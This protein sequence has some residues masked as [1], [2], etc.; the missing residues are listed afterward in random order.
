MYDDWFLCLNLKHNK[1]TK[2]VVSLVSLLINQIVHCSWR[3]LVV[4]ALST[5]EPKRVRPM[6]M[7]M[8]YAFTVTQQLVLSESITILR[9]YKYCLKNN[10]KINMLLS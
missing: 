2:V 1:G 6:N 7:N 4:Y 8:I 5:A 10:L 9:G 3:A